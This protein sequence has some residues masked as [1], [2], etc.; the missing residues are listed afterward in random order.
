MHKNSHFKIYI[1]IVAVILLAILFFG[2]RVYNKYALD[3][4]VE[5]I[6]NKDLT[7]GTFNKDT[8]TFFEYKKVEF[9]IKSYIYDYSNNIQKANNII[10]DSQIKQVLSAKNYESDGPKFTKSLALLSSKKEEFNKIIEKLIH[11]NDEK[12]ILS[13]IEK[14]KISDDFKELYK[15][16]ML[17]RNNQSDLKKNKELIQEISNKGILVFET[18][19]K[20]INLLKNNTDKWVVKDSKIYFYSS[21]V[22]KEYNQLVEK[23]K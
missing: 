20:V 12:V 19:E 7:S 5:K 14:E 10:N 3:S 2:F 4:E 17:N 15:K 13:Y 9:A 6:L 23:V 8:I 21:S 18:D 22:M 11:M 1:S 16:Y